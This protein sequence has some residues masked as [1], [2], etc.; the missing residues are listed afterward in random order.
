MRTRKI[1]IGLAIIGMALTLP[2]FAQGPPGGAQSG[3]SLKADGFVAEVNTSK[4][5]KI[6]KAEWA[7]AGLPDI[8]DQLDTDKNGYLTKEKL[9]AT[10]FPAAFDSNKDG[11]LTVAKFLAFSKV[12]HGSGGAPGGG[13]PGAPPS[14]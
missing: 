4:T 13:A 9:E 3:V 10:K 12:I 1:A 5:G 11:T 6:T 8:F 2:S 14:N 7:A